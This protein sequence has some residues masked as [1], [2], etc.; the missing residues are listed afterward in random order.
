[1]P[2]YEDFKLIVDGRA[3]HYTVEAQGPL[4]I[5]VPPIPMPFSLEDDFGR[6]AAAM[7]NGEALTRQALELVGGRLFEALFQTRIFYAYGRARALR[8]E[9]ISLRLKLC[10]RPPELNHLPW[11]LL[12]DAVEGTGFL[13]LNLDYPITRYIESA[14]PAASLLARRPLRILYV[15]ATPD[16]LPPLATST[17]YAGLLQ[18]LGE[19][20]EITAIHNASLED[21]QSA[22]RQAQYHVLHYDGHAYFD[23][24]AQ[25]GYLCFSDASR[26][27]QK[28]SG[29]TLANYLAGSSIR[30]ALLAACQTASTSSQKRFAG[31]A[32]R[33]M[34][35]SALPA[36]IAMQFPLEDASALA[37]GRGFYSAL[38]DRYPV[39]A[40][41]VEGRKAVQGILGERAYACTDWANAVLFMRA[42]DGDILAS[43]ETT[44]E[45]LL[46][47]LTQFHEH[48]ERLQ[49]WKDLHDHLD[50]IM[51][52]LNPFAKA[53]ERADGQR[54]ILERRSLVNL[55]DP[56]VQKVKLMLDWAEK[57]KFIGVRYHQ[58]E[59][60]EMDGAEWAVKLARLCSELQAH[61]GAGRG[62]A[63]ETAEANYPNST[64]SALYRYFNINNEW[65]NI[66]QQLTDEFEH[67]VYFHMH[68]ADKSLRQA[69]Q[70]LYEFSRQK[71]ADTPKE[72]ER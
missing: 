38:V 39:D 41:V 11:E 32:Y 69:A 23:E 43:N 20:A 49:E 31:I 22:L 53:I 12:Y 42:P 27:M 10:I 16:D 29:E 2:R 72:D 52:T 5:N 67:E 17:S 60:G 59:T 50:G 36:V 8:A 57:I 44:Q 64:Q 48:H 61:L 62:P 24:S 46:E 33:L 35:A 66:L 3:G 40:A 4:Q 28:V 56:V 6:A 30:L 37:F 58:A 51:N 45:A 70:I 25:E 18:S 55:Y 1:M 54:Q 9:N 68:K 15:S 19:Q 7:Q 63:R 65:W 71:L 14:T 47:V 34:L 13:A 26:R 21:L